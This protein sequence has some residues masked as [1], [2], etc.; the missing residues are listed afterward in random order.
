MKAFCVMIVALMV[1]CGG[2]PPLVAV[3]EED[4]GIGG[5]AG[6]TEEVVP[7]VLEVAD[8]G[9]TVVDAGLP[10]N[11]GNNPRCDVGRG[12]KL[13]LIKHGKCEPK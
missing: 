6:G 2:S 7:P 9:V 4:A 3:E 5:T 8:S 10:G 12:K 13:G 1:A 11:S